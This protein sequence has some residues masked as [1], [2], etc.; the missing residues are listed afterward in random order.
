[1]VTCVFR[2]M[3]LLEDYI[4]GNEFA[5]LGDKPFYFL[6]KWDVAFDVCAKMSWQNIWL[7][8]CMCA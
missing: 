6:W 7:I 2:C 5:Y 8:N 4:V 1:M 3:G